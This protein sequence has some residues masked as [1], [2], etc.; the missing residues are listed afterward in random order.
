MLPAVMTPAPPL[1]ASATETLAAAVGEGG[2]FMLAGGDRGG[3]LF[4]ARRGPGA[5]EPDQ[6]RALWRVIFKQHAGYDNG[7]SQG[8]QGP[9]MVK[10]YVN[11]YLNWKALRAQARRTP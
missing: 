8:S 6:K 4:V 1:P 10:Q 9:K 5:F 11:A 3:A 7:R 2:E